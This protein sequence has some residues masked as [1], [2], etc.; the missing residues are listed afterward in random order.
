MLSTRE[1]VGVETVHTVEELVHRG[2]EDSIVIGGGSVYRALLGDCAR[3]YVTKI[4]MVAEA[5]D[6]WFPNLDQ[7]QEWRVADEGTP[8]TEQG[9]TF[10]F[11][12]YQRIADGR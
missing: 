5:P 4:D 3:V 6:T 8:V 12:E 1:I 9:I 10:R 7:C 2:G 11:V